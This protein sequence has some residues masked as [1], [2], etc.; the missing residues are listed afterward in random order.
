MSS[1]GTV[2]LTVFDP[3]AESLARLIYEH[4]MLQVGGTSRATGED[5]PTFMRS[6]LEPRTGGT[7]MIF[8]DESEPDPDGR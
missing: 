3:N 7:Y 5:G 8:V 4:G 6:L 2:S 1:D